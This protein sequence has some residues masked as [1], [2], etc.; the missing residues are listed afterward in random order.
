LKGTEND[1]KRLNENQT[2]TRRVVEIGTY[3]MFPYRY[4]VKQ[5]EMTCTHNFSETYGSVS[6]RPP[7]K[8]A[9]KKVPPPFFLDDAG[10][11][12]RPAKSI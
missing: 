3:M 5:E 12:P 7:N 8:M 9:G 2:T 4:M 6:G 11:F 1:T 10:F